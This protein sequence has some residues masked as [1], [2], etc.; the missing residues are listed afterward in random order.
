MHLLLFSAGIGRRY[1]SKGINGIIAEYGRE[2]NTFISMRLIL[3]I[4]IVIIFSNVYNLKSE[5]GKRMT[6]EK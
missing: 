5:S 1:N 3:K 4:S 6:K 2:Y